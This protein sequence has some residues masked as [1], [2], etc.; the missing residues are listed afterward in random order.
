MSK[1]KLK[2]I[3]DLARIAQVSV[4]SASM[5]MNGKWE[6]KVKAETAE[7]ILKIATEYNYKLNPLGRS[8]QKNQF[9]RV[10]ILMEGTFTEHPLLGAFSFHD[11]I[12][13]ASDKLNSNG[14]SLDIIQLDKAKQKQIIKCGF[15]PKNVDALIFLQWNPDTLKKL[16]KKVYPDQ[17][18]IVLG[19]DLKKPKWSCIYR[20]TEKISYQAVKHFVINGHKRIA[21]SSIAGSKIR[22]KEKL[23]GY[24]KALKEAGI[25]FDPKLVIDLK[26]TTHSMEFGASLAENFLSLKKPPTAFFCDDNIDALGMLVHFQKAGYK[27]PEQIEIIGYGDE[28]LANMAPLPL[29]YLKIPN[30]EMAESSIEYILSALNSKSQIKPI[31]KKIPETIIFQKTTR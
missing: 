29:S 31:H 28:A 26:H 23:S 16:F 17:P 11:F 14:Y 3:R 25:T 12:G 5:V 27:I 9:F 6:K 21:I 18:C 1:Q 4:G 2:T 22:F 30:K 8:L 13:I 19:E 7:K 24:K 20:D 15:F 10:A